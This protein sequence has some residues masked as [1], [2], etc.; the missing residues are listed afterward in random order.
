M[1]SNAVGEAR[2]FRRRDGVVGVGHW[3]EWAGLV[4]ASVSWPDGAATRHQDD[5]FS[6]FGGYEDLGPVLAVEK[7]D[8]PGAILILSDAMKSDSDFAFTWHANISMAAI[9]EGCKPEIA[10]QAASRFMQMAFGVM[11][12]DHPGMALPNSPD[13]LGSNLQPAET[14][15][16]EPEILPPEP[17][18]PIA[19]QLPALPPLEVAA[20]PV[21]VLQ[22][23]NDYLTQYPDAN[24]EQVVEHLAL[25]DVVTTLQEVTNVRNALRGSAEVES[26]TAEQSANNA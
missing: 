23:I 21:S 1:E 6:K 17:T 11:E 20:E 4:Q 8:V 14:I 15:T 9:D 24:T 22:A 12:I 18:S 3:I 16:G 25:N 26:A 19:D 10:H 7:T 13:L 2:R 5:E